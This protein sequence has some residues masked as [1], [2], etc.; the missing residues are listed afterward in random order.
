MAKHTQQT[1]WGITAGLSFVDEYP[2]IGDVLRRRGIY[3]DPTEAVNLLISI[4]GASRQGFNA[5]FRSIENEFIEINSALHTANATTAALLTSSTNTSRVKQVPPTSFRGDPENGAAKNEEEYTDWKDHLRLCFAADPIAFKEERSKFLF[6]FSY[7]AGTA[8]DN[9]RENIKLVVDENPFSPWKDAE[10]FIKQLDLQYEVTNP[11]QQASI[12]F[13][14]H[15]QQDPR[16]KKIMPWPNFLAVF[17][18]LATRSGKTSEQ[19][20]DALLKKTEPRM[21]EK[22]SNLT[23]PPKLDDFAG[24][25]KLG[26]QFYDN[27]QR[28]EH[29]QQSVYGK[30]LHNNPFRPVQAS[31]NAPAKD[32][33]AMD[34]DKLSLSKLTDAERQR[35]ITNGLC[36]RCRQSGHQSQDCPRFGAGQTSNNNA[37]VPYNGGAPYNP[38][39]YNTAGP[40]Y[41][42][43]QNT[44]GNNPYRN[45]NNNR[46]QSPARRSFSPGRGGNQQRRNSYDNLRRMEEQN[47]G[48]FG[49]TAQ[50]ELPQTP[51]T[52]ITG[53]DYLNYRDTV[54]SSHSSHLTAQSTGSSIYDQGNA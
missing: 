30:L 45:N 36:F 25:C 20:V 37:M 39:Q 46:S 26:N 23:E 47:Q 42:G 51:Q 18:N 50:P 9:H 13:D 33:N 48:P 6:M 5:L 52:N 35:C 8:K 43:Y 10:A 38:Q 49:F 12:N 31:T 15:I 53:P 54:P 4:N 29:N 11:K 41:G 40:A 3:A 1:Q 16:T 7:L 19:K 22:F 14:N 2:Q 28:L 44:G 21:Q 32:P 27:I 17:T 24:W 34:L